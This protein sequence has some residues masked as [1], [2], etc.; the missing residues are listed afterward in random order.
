MATPQELLSAAYAD[1]TNAHQER[2]L[3]RR[4]AGFEVDEGMERVLRLQ[5]ADAA[6]YASLSVT[7][8]VAAGVVRRAQASRR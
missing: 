8:R 2:D 5:A 6:A 1:R 4:A 7:T 3:R